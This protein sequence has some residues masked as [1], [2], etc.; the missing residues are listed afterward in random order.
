MGADSFGAQTVYRL[1]QGSTQFEKQAVVGSP[2]ALLMATAIARAKPDIDC[3]ER[4][5]PGV[6]QR[7]ACTHIY[8]SYTAKLSHPLRNTNTSTMT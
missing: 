4:F 1:V 6:G 2:S 3:S 7:I 8:R 5:L